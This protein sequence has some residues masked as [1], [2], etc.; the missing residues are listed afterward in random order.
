[1]QPSELVT[2]L[3]TLIAKLETYDIFPFYLRLCMDR[4]QISQSQLARAIYV[5]PAAVNQWLSNA[6]LPSLAQIVPIAQA[7]KLSEQEANNLH[8]A[9]TIQRLLRDQIEFLQ[10]SHAADA[11]VWAVQVVE[12][13]ILSLGRQYVPEFFADE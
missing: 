5:T 6:R 11:S 13:F 9:L 1:M 2:R 10:A 7:L 3:E 4:K 12:P 8:A